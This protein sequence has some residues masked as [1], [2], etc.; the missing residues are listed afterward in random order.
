MQ[1]VI[2]GKAKSRII[3]TGFEKV[4]KN[5]YLITN[6]NL[7]CSHDLKIGFFHNLNVYSH[8]SLNLSTA[9]SQRSEILLL[10]YII[11]PL[12]P[13][14][15]N[16]TI[17][18][19][20]SNVCSTID[21][22]F[23]EVQQFSGRYVLLYKNDSHFIAVGDACSLRQRYYAFFEDNIVLTSSPKMYLDLFGYDA[24]I[25]QSKKAFI[26]L[27]EYEKTAH[28][29][30]GDKCID[31]R[32]MKV[33]PN[34]FIDIAN[35]RVSRT[36]IYYKELVGDQDVL[37]FSSAILMGTFDAIIRRYRIIQPL[38]AGW[39]TRTLLAA[40]KNVKDKI[41][42]YVCAGPELSDGHPDIVVPLRLSKRLGLNFQVLRVEELK[43]E[44]LDVYTREHIF[45]RIAYNTNYIQYHY[46]NDRQDNIINVTGSVAE[47]FRCFYGYTNCKINEKMLLCFSGYFNKSDYVKEEI[48]NWLDGVKEFSEQ[49]EIPILDLFYWE[50]RMGNWGALY[51]SEQ[52]IA[53]EEFSP[54]NNKDML[55][56]ILR[57]NRRKRASPNFSFIYKLIEILWKEATVEPIDPGDMFIK[58]LI[59]RY[60]MLRYYSL[61]AISFFANHGAAIS[62][63]GQ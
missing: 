29:W 34:H 27:K 55:L 63:S 22:L 59:K 52:D 49:F 33:L 36:P 10:G 48:A 28:A 24:E 1:P 56:S 23:K 8:P 12:R 53:I 32:L 51:P 9:K 21:S 54:F 16:D 13:E 19:N 4:Y 5:Q 3:S 30:F 37:E 35:K 40:C 45:P 61:K 14:E 57:I 42:F 15:D 58:K 31:D 46:Y 26:N 11:N 43:R 44:F 6:K 20:L 60:S 7:S 2:S 50:Q 17:V 39:D 25:S 38:T 62:P 41:Q 47:V 18:S